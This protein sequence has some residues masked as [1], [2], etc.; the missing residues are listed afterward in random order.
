MEA[1]A[2]AGFKPFGQVLV[3]FI[4]VWQRYNLKGSSKLSNLSPVASSRESTIQRYD[5]N[6]ID[7]HKITTTIPLRGVAPPPI[8]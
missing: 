2:L 3:Q 8:T 1:M 4:I 6:K 5:C 7:G